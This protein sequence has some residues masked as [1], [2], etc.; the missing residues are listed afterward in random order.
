MADTFTLKLI[1]SEV[2]PEKIIEQ[3]GLENSG[4][5]QQFIDNQCLKLCN[6]HFVP[7]DTHNLIELSIA[8]TI[9][10]SGELRYRG[11]YARHLYYHPEFNFGHDKN[12]EAGGY[13]FERMK[14]QYK[15]QI[16]EGAAKKAGA[17]PV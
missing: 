13:W 5:V 16:L 17:K 11:P 3:R 7:F 10:G 4:K 12:A 6:D 2:D 9:I 1:K 8:N 14:Q 15:Q